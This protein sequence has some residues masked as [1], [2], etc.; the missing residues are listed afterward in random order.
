MANMTASAMGTNK[1]RETPCKKNIGTNTIQM[2]SK[3]TK[4]AVTI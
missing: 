4:A 1:K 2:H 3:E